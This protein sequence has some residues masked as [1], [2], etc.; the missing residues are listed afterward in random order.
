M[1]SATLVQLIESHWREI[2]SRVIQ[3]IRTQPE[4]ASLAKKSDME[5]R[6]WCQAILENL[7]YFLGDSNPEEI[8]RRYRTQGRVR[9]EEQIPLHEAVL[10]TQVLKTKIEGFV[11]E[12]G[13]PRT[14]VQ[15]YA[16]EE[17]DHRLAHFFD[18]MLYHLVSG[19][20]DQMRRAYG[21]VPH[22]TMSMG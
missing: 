8:E 5:L 18:A 10:R 13:Y 15:L 12:Q 21:L 11:A 14:A 9:F 3:A 17:L 19:Y 2:A 22:R 16:E 7:G 6:E 1:L 20:E 4:M